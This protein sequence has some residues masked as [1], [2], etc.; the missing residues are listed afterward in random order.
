MITYT[1]EISHPTD[2]FT[3]VNALS[4]NL[5]FLTENS[6]K[7]DNE[8]MCGT[9]ELI[10]FNGNNFA[11]ISNLNFLTDIR[12]TFI[13]DYNEYW[14]RIVFVNVLPNNYFS[15]QKTF[16][17]SKEPSSSKEGFK[18][19]HSN[20]WLQKKGH[21]KFI[22]LYLSERNMELY[23]QPIE[24]LNQSG[25]VSEN[26]LVKVF[27]DFEIDSIMSQTTT[28]EK[29]LNQKKIILNS[30]CQNL[31]ETIFPEAIIKTQ[32]SKKQLDLEGIIAAEKTLTSNFRADVLTLEELSRIAGMN[33]TK[34]QLLFREL[35]GTSFYTHFQKKRF[36]YAKRLIEEKKYN[37]TEAALAIGFK[38]Y[39]HFSK[40]FEVFIGYKPSSAKN[41]G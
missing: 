18:A 2:Y 11:I 10:Q 40:Q 38:N 9:R 37:V 17:H 36:E 1:L 31:I 20:T 32:R 15:N 26:L 4:P 24:S 39:S 7:V 12:F 28:S 13:I 6:V 34:F 25:D 3:K 30:L 41:N 8:L 27:L 22:I 5:E 35:Y 19:N 16:H 33:K 23:S 14:N 21:V 29:I